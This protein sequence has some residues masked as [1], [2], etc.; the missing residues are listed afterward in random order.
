MEIKYH[1]RF[2]KN[3]KKRIVSNPK[4]IE[5]FEERLEKF[6]ENPNNPILKNHKLAGKMEEYRAFSVSGDLRVVYKDIG[7]EIWLYDIGTHNQV[8]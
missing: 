8:Y 7:D 4:L 6:K 3:F 2:L 5:Q 1:K